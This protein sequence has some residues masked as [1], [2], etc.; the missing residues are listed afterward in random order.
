MSRDSYSPSTNG[1]DQDDSG[2][3]GS[4]PNESNSESDAS[5]SSDS[6]SGSDSDSDVEVVINHR[7]YVNTHTAP[8]YIA[9]GGQH[10][11]FTSKPPP[12]DFKASWWKS[13]TV[14]ASWEKRTPF[15]PCKHE[16][17]CDQAQCRCFRHGITCEKICSCSDSCERRFPGCSCA[18][19][20]NGK[21]TPCRTAKCLCL[22]MGR[23]CD[24]D[25]CG[26][27][28]ATEILDPVN[29]YN[30]DLAKACGNVAIQRSVPKKTFLGHSEVHGFGLYVGE[31][32]QKDDFIGEYVGEVVSVRE[33]ER[34][35]IVYTRQQTMYLFKLNSG[36]SP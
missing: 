8:P 25:L 23:E 29:R 35:G 3:G 17:P 5:H 13:K 36:K 28:G 30:E 2:D 18:Q 19:S 24:A 12:G 27:C 10:K 31:D 16:G 33:G 15:F 11:G 7:R 4:E 22:T 1:S 32:T 9:S 20:A 26:S 14:T 6:D 21:Q 34:R